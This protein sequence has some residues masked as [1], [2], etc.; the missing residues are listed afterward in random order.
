MKFIITLLSL[1]LCASFSFAQEEVEL[2]KKAYSP[3]IGFGVGTIGFYGDLNDRKYGS[4]LGGNIGY[5]VYLIQPIADFLNIKFNLTISEIKAEERSEQRNVNFQ[6]DLRAGGMYLEYNFDNFLPEKRKVTPFITA[7]IE[8]VE[9]NPKTDLESFTGETYNY[10]SDGTIR[11]LPE[12]SPNAADQAKLLQRDYRYETDIREAGFNPSKSYSER[13]YSIPVGVGV[14]MHLNDQFDFRFESIMHLTF[15][16]YIDGITPNTSS[17]FVG[18]KR[19]NANNDYF[20]FNGISLSYNFQRV[21]PAEK[22]QR[23][24]KGE[25]IDYAALGN[26]EDY[27]SDGVIDL[28]DRCPNTPRDASVDST[29]CALDSDGD[30]VPDYKDEEINTEYPEFA[31]EKGVEMTDDMIYDSYLRFIDSTSAY[32]EVV[33]R[34]FRGKAKNKAVYKVQL[35]EF[36]KGETP[37]SMGEFLSLPDLTKIDINKTTIFAAGNFSSMADAN[38]RMMQLSQ[39]GFDGLQVIKREKDGSYTKIGGPLTVS[40]TEVANTPTST[41]TPAVVNSKPASTD[42]EVPGISEAEANSQEVVFRV[43]LGA[44]KNKPSAGTYKSIPNLIVV[45]SGGFYRYMSG[46][47]DNF[48]EAASH[49]VKMS[50]EGYKGAFVVAYKGG[51]RVPLKSV[52]VNSISSDPIIGQ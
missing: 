10:W 21:E 28:I 51:K 39:Q 33:E 48:S 1:F 30:G 14:T 44:F 22:Y 41:K 29:G 31:N 43:Q 45:E 19:G 25:I 52:G 17:D 13:A 9:F 15:T 18:S 49:K 38:S 12:N 37:A 5:N 23:Y 46:S 11:S 2:S 24:E 20:F 36:P 40:N 47:F 4:P 6:T 3:T 8:A 42:S 27:D 26:T 50:V 7:G 32:A 35:G 16:D 34:D